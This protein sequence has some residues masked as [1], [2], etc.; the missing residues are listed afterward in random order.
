LDLNVIYGDHFTGLYSSFFK[1][2][3]FQQ[4]LFSH[5]EP[6]LHVLWKSNIPRYLLWEYALPVFASYG[7]Q[8]LHDLGK[9]KVS[10]INVTLQVLFKVDNFKL[11]SLQL[12][13]YI[14]FPFFL[15]Y[16]NELGPFLGKKKKKN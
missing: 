3:L 9:H 14:M 12:N 7:Q 10:K 13:E 11:M 1:N 15:G 8:Y 5:T 6:A 4:P 2:F 16:V